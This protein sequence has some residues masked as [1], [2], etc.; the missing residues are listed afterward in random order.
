V[1]A[2]REAIA[3][4]FIDGQYRREAQP[5][6]PIVERIDEL[7]ERE[8]IALDFIDSQYRREAQ[9]LDPIVERIDEFTEPGT[10]ILAPAALD[11]H[12]DHSLRSRPRSPSRIGAATSSSTPTSPT[13]IATG[14]PGG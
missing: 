10:V 12:P 2:G 4:D 3:L 6:D 11:A 14:G 1:L 8:A 5:L 7:T 9:P 13:A